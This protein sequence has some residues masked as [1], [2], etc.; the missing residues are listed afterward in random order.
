M[1]EKNTKTF[2]SLYPYVDFVDKAFVYDQA[3][4]KYVYGSNM[5]SPTSVETPEIWHGVINPAVGRVWNGADDIAKIG[6]FLDKTHEFYTKS[7][8]FAPMNTPPKVLYYDGFSESKSISARALFQYNLF[9]QNRENVA[10]NRF[11]KYLLGDISHALQSYDA[12]SADP[13]V[14]AMY[15][16]LGIPE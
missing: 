16:S 9:I 10:Y 8:K 1:V 14:T 13:D 4:R 7:G 12:K 11:T 3:A 5:S 15:Q 2:A 6:Q